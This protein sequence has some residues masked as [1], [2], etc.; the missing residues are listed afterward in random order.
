MVASKKINVQVEEEDEA[1]KQKATRLAMY[2]YDPDMMPYSELQRGIGGGKMRIG[3]TFDYRE[4]MFSLLF[5]S[6]LKRNLIN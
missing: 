6:G 2:E 3:R 5:V 1:L 4:D